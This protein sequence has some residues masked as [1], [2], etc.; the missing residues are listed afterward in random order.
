MSEAYI[1]DL[2]DRDNHVGKL[3]FFYPEQ[4]PVN[5]VTLGIFLP[6]PKFLLWWVFDEPL[7]LK[8]DSLACFASKL[9]S[10]LF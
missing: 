8:S 4:T 9:F 3:V 10:F 2:G 6:T 1:P 5:L 7:L